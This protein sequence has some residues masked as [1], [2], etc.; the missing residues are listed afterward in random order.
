[1]RHAENVLSKTSYSLGLTSVVPWPLGR[2]KIE[3]VSV[4]Y[5]FHLCIL[6]LLGWNGNLF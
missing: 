6:H 5:R 1:M 2:L 3:W 4:T